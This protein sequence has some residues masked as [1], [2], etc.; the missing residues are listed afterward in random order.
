MPYCPNPDCPHRKRLGEPAEFNK[1]V[2]VC[3]DCGSKL[4]ETV[5]HFEPIQQRE[6]ARGWKCP[7]CGSVNPDD[8]SICSCGYDSNKPFK[9]TPD[10]KKVNK[11]AQ[12]EPPSVPAELI[13]TGQER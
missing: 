2:D 8:I 9:M 3:S 13:L 11:K 4:F 1:D 10:E 7:E 5:P 6:T 12:H